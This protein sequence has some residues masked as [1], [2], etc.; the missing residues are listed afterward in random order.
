MNSIYGICILALTL[1]PAAF[2]TQAPA[3][4][5]LS[6]DTAT[7]S[8]SWT[9]KKV[10]GSAHNGSVKVE[11]GTFVT[12]NGTPVSGDVA[13]DLNTITNQDLTDAG[14]NAKLVGHLK[15][16]DFFDVAKFKNVNLKLTKITLLKNA[17]AGAPNL[18]Y[19]GD[20]T[21]KGVTKKVSG[22]ANYKATDTGFSTTGELKVDRT[23]FGLKY[24]SGK[25]FKDLGDKVIADEIALSFNLV[26]KK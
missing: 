17:A 16:E 7:S 6:V 4:T 22:L 2:A 14:Y 20:L 21:I 15:S 5:T 24:G 3:S 10:V 11:K 13:I 9:G 1:A 23:D 26:A 19:E 12:K 18:S 8:V 25:F